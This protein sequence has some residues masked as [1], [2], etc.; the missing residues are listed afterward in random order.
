MKINE[1]DLD[2]V[3]G[4]LRVDHNVDDDL[5]NTMI[6]AAKNFIQFYLNRKFDEFEEIPEEFTIALLAIV[7]HWYENRQIQSADS[8]QN[9]LP[10]IFSDL[11][12]L[13]R[14]WNNESINE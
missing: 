14:N 8:T 9:E 4:Y 12:D 7:A 3:K 6:V 5:I 13:Y 1:V 2:F 11:L 10:Y